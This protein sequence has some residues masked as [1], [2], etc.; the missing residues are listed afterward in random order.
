MLNHEQFTRLA[1]L[2]MDTVFRL[3]FNYTKAD[4]KQMTSP[5]MFSLSSIT[6]IKRLTARSILSIG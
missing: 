5:R 2:Y 4:Q 6:R 1:K 3:A